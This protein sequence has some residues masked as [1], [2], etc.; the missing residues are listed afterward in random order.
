M[1][2]DILTEV[3]VKKLYKEGS[4]SIAAF[5]AG[6]LAG[7]YLMAENFRSLGKPVAARITIIGTIAF[8]LLLLLISVF[9]IADKIPNILFSVLYALTASFITR[10][11]QHSGIQQHLSLGGA[12]YSGSRVFLIG[13][14]CLVL[15]IAILIG[16]LYLLDPSAFL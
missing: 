5:L 6:P 9:P 2:E 15:T 3:P 8:I 4:I 14:I 13:I 16:G 11:F 7:G 1:Q 12:M 10:K